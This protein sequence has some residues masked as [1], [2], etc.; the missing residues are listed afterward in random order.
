MSKERISRYIPHA[1]DAIEKEF[2]KKPISSTYNSYIS[3]FGA[4]IVQS[5]LLPT[6]AAYRNPNANTKEDKSKILELI[7]NIL[8]SAGEI[9]EGELLDYVLSNKNDED[10]IKEKIK[11]AAVALKLSLRTFRTFELEE[12]D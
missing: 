12:G 3:S 2:G 7:Q 6:L 1:I 10:I 8:Q 9:P 5:G 4:S 11:D